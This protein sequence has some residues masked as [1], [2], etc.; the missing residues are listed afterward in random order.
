MN[1]PNQSFIFLPKEYLNMLLNNYILLYP[2]ESKLLEMRLIFLKFKVVF[3][4]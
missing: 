1:D 2:K 3:N 4:A